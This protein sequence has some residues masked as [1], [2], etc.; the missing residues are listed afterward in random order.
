MI[1]KIEAYKTPDGKIWL[2]E[3]DAIEHIESAKFKVWYRSKPENR[4]NGYHAETIEI[5]KWL[6]E[7]KKILIDY[8]QSSSID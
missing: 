3:K 7:H 1:A 4:L 6:I 2:N 8:L 5:Y